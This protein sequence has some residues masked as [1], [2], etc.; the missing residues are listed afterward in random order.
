M[1]RVKR[2][3]VAKKRRKKTLILASGFQGSHSNCF[4]PSN[5]QAIKS[6]VYANRDRNRRKRDFRK[7]WIT[8]I[9][10]AARQQG[11][12]YSQFIHKLYKAKIYINRKMLAQTAVLDPNTFTAFFSYIDY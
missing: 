11:I 1:T 5:Q 2:G 8:R 9:N 3:Y 10:A 12:S 6:L 4:R 7:L